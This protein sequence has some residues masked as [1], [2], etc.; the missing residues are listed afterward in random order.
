MLDSVTLSSSQPFSL[1]A[2]PARFLKAVVYTLCLHFLSTHPLLNPLQSGFQ[3]T[4][5]VLS[6][7]LSKVVRH[8]LLPNPTALRRLMLLALFYSPGGELCCLLELS[9]WLCTLLVHLLPSQPGFLGPHGSFSSLPCP[10]RHGHSPPVG[11][12]PGGHAPEACTHSQPAGPSQVPA[13]HVSPSH[14]SP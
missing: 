9:S 3:A 8:L 14:S 6:K 11:P 7:V 10:P 12:S 13:A 4:E 1:L 5:A 2:S